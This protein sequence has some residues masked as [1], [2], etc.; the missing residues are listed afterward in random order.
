MEILV[1]VELTYETKIGAKFGVPTRNLDGTSVTACLT[2]YRESATALAVLP[3]VEKLQALYP[4]CGVVLVDE[5]PCISDKGGNMDKPPEVWRL[6]FRP[7]LEA[8][9][10]KIIDYGAELYVLGSPQASRS[11]EI[12]SMFFLLHLLKPKK[13]FWISSPTYSI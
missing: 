13:M 3:M 6:E 5:W 2:S 8:F 9:V 10:S 11:F 12:P 1:L 4:G 7:I